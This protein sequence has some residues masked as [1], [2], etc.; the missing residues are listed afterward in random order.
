MQFFSRNLLSS[1]DWEPY[2]HVGV[3]AFR[4]DALQQFVGLKES[5]LEKQ[6]RL[7]QLRALEAGMRSVLALG[8]T[9]PDGVDTPDDLER[10]RSLLK[11]S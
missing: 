8:V 1:T 9:V 3:Y 7:E 2:H 5:T 4:R 6:E 10:V 11:N